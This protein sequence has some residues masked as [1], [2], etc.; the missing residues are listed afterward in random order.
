MKGSRMKIYPQIAA[1][2]KPPDI[3]ACKRVLCIQPHPDDNEIGMGGTIA[4]LA[5]SGCEIHYLTVTNGDMGNI[6]QSATPEQTAALRRAE[7]EAAGRCL[8]A[9]RFYFLEH[10]DG[11][12]SDIRGLS[13]EVAKIIRQVRPEALFCP[14]PWLP[15]EGHL[16]HIVT[17][18]AVS[19]AFHMSGQIHFP[20]ESEPWR[21]AAIGYYFT[22]NHN[23]VI[24]IT[25]TFEQ[26]FKAIALHKSQIDT[27]TKALYKA[28]FEMK[29]IELAKKKI[30]RLGEGLKVLSGLHTHCFVD[31]Y[32]I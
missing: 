8:G 32:K 26:K 28:Y 6:D 30:F 5:Q 25:D 20:D 7:T 4:A 3:T 21:A 14:D 15:Y 19:N 22:A 24:N 11:T 23:T 13:V 17:G 29:G 2:L 27:Q 18:R 31:A 10:G 1:L 9:T 12:L 16:D